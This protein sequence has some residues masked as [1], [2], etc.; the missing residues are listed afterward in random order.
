MRES[1]IEKKVCD[2]AKANGWL[3]HPK[4]GAGYRGW[5]DRLFSRVDAGRTRMLFV[6]FKAPT[7]K[8][9]ALQAHTHQMLAAQEYEVHVINS[10]AAGK[11]L[12][13]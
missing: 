11:A 6:E 5:P 13:T 4:A 9:T 1:A 8:P 10:V 3:V 12:L 7:G 2:F